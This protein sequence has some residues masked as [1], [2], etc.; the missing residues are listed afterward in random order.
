L[1]QLRLV[2]RQILDR[3][4][5]EA[6]V[7]PGIVEA[8]DESPAAVKERPRSA[9]QGGAG[10]T[11][12]RLIEE[13]V[14]ES[15]RRGDV[16]IVGRG[17]HMI[18]AGRPGLLRVKVMAPVEIRVASLMQRLSLSRVAAERAVRESDR[19]RAKFI[20]LVYGAD[21]MDPG[22]YDLVVNTKHISYEAAAEAIAAIARHIRERTE[23][24]APV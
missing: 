3:V 15:A 20:K 1:L 9:A 16:L 2:D 14:L 10:M 7:P 11:Y 4:A 23:S 18:L 8:V 19:A 6:G 17:A 13:A 12:G 21:W 24:G 22:Q 5:D